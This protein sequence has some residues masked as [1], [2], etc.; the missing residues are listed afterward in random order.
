MRDA[1]TPPNDG[2]DAQ[3]DTAPTPQQSATTI[4]AAAAE[5]LIRVQ[6]WRSSPNW[7]DDDTNR[8]RYQL[9]LDAVAAIDK[10]PDPEAVPA[11]VDAVRPL[12][13]EWRPSRPSDQ[14]AIY[15]AVERLQNVATGF[16]R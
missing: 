14:Q 11:L 12:L 4:R 6:E 3:L 8:H 10:L 5:V 16:L 7:R 2:H 1:A 9:T 13:A 15:A